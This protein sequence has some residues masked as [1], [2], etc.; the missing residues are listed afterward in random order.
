MSSPFTTKLFAPSG[1]P[2][3][4]IV[5]S[6]DDWT[7]RAIIFP[8]ELVGEVKGRKEYS[9]PGVYLLVSARKMYIGEGD[10]VGARIDSHVANKDFWRRGLIFTAEGRRLNKAHIQHLESRLVSLAKE[11]GRIGLMNGNHPKPPVLSEEEHAFCEIFLQQMLLTLPL[12]GFSQ[13]LTATDPMDDEEEE[14]ED[15]DDNEKINDNTFND[16]PSGKRASLYSSLPQGQIYSLDSL[17]TKATLATT[18]FGVL[19]Q[20]G[21][22]V[23]KN[24]ST[25]FELRSP[26]Y[27]AQ[28]RQLIEAG[29]IDQINGELIFTK[30]QFFSS[31]AAAASVVR[32]TPSTAYLWKANDGKTLG[33]KIHDA[34]NKL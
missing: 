34:K 5:A 19:V 8:R 30:D 4:V 27:A 28:R 18:N 31:G 26:N 33:S 10:P 13:F 9:E 1:S 22:Q 29:V 2:D 6:R 3:G 12:L 32:G 21:S 24:E 25:S 15:E 14:Q 17:G 16:T 20:K 11:V 23:R 7:G